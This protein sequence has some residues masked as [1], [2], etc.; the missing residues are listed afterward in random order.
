M[1]QNCFILKTGGDWD[2]TTLYSNGREYFADFL[3]IEIKSNRDSEEIH[4][5]GGIA[6]GGTVQ[7]YVSPQGSNGQ[8]E[9]ICPG[10]IEMVFPLHK[11]T[12]VNEAPQLDC[13]NTQILL[14]E[15]NIS[16]QLIDMLIEIN[17]LTNEVQAYLTLYK[18][19]ILGSDAIA[20]LN[21]L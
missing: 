1:L 17:A 18:H 5:H 14:D 9:S 21:L 11:L 6:N 16:D 15:I 12:F 2:S 8:Q 19:H 3:Y 4:T 10:K 7:A 20:T 13:E